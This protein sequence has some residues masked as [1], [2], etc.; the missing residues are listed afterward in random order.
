MNSGIPMTTTALLACIVVALLLLGGL[1]LLGRWLLRALRSHSRVS[2]W[3]LAMGFVITGTLLLV[4]LVILWCLVEY[5][6]FGIDLEP[7]ALRTLMDRA[8]I[9][10]PL[11]SI[12]LMVAHSFVPFPAELIAIANGL[13]FGLTGGIAVT[14][15]GAMA[16]AILAYELARAL[17]PTARTR[18]VPARYQERL[19]DLV[20]EFGTRALLIARLAP[21]ISFNLVN[22]GAGLAGVGRFTFL[23]TTAIGIVPITALSVLVGSQALKL[24]PYLWLLAGIVLAIALLAMHRIRRSIERRG[25][26]NSVTVTETNCQRADGSA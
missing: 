15:L 26:G 16:G 24:P 17:G 21:V 7:A 1:L 4:D 19:D 11:V 23:W 25:K 10:A 2:R 14:W 13:A 6:L 3:W 22:Y 9:W 8:G 18:L 12:A 5:S 20:G